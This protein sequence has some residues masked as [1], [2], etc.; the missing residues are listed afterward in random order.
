MQQSEGKRAM[1]GVFDAFR[2]ALQAATLRALP[3]ALR[4]EGL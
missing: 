1:T 2:N 4:I 3:G